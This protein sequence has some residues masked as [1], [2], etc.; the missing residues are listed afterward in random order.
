GNQNFIED[1]KV[2]LGAL[3][4]GRKI[5]ADDEKYII[6]EH[7]ASYNAVFDAKKCNLSAQNSYY[8]KTF[9][10]NSNT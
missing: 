8:W 6:Q 1:M 3:A 7:L 9:H 5:K 10:E 2:S 4:R